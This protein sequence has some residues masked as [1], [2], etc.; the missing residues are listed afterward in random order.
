LKTE[1]GKRFLTGALQWDQ[2]PNT[3]VIDKV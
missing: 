1:E 2:K 3:E